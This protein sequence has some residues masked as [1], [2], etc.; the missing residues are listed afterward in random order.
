MKNTFILITIFVNSM[1]SHAQSSYKAPFYEC[2][3]GEKYYSGEDCYKSFNRPEYMM[4][5]WNFLNVPVNYK[6]IQSGLTKISYKLSPNFN[7]TKKTVIYFNGGPGGTSYNTNFDMLN[8]VNVIYFNQRGSAFSRPET[9]QLFLDTNY[10]SSENTARD[11][12]EIIKHLGIN[13]VT[14]YGMS[15]GTVPATIFGSLFPQNTENVILEGVV[16]DG[17]Q[18]LWHAEHR[19]NI[20]QKYFDQL[21]SNLKSN[22]IYFSNHPKV[23]PGWFSKMSQ[24]YMYNSNFKKVLSDTLNS[25]FKNYSQNN[26]KSENEIIESLKMFSY[27]N[28]GSSDDMIFFSPN[29]FNFIACKELSS[30]SN[31]STFYATF[32]KNNKLVPYVKDD[33]EVNHCK[34]LG[35]NNQSIYSSLNYKLS[36]PVYYFQ[37]INDGAT[38]ADFAIWH[39]KKTANSK[40]QIILA[41]NE[42]HLVTIQYLSTLPK[43]SE[44]DKNN[45]EKI[46]KY[47]LQIS[48]QKEVVLAFKAAINNEDVDLTKIN[49]LLKNKKNF[50]VKAQK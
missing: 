34:R 23:F 20:L 30:Q 19:L 8:D 21:D 2:F 42:G 33:T 50:W 12:L 9:I 6:D 29:M 28:L 40:A 10:Y 15:Y 35:I 41:K 13:K 27:N 3:S 25:I 4:S 37:G 22:I 39:Y 5:G 48:L 49:N 11:A 32:N 38:T 17:S 43:L 26:I 31:T 16:Y 18:K 45:I 47:E 1:T 46:Q 36:V 24:M 14:A 7:K 44:A